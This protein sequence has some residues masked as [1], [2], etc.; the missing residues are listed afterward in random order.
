M[1]EFMGDE[2][3]LTAAGAGGRV[4]GEDRGAGVFHTAPAEATDD[5]LG[6]LVPWVGFIEYSAV[7][8]DHRRR[9]AENLR[10]SLTAA[11]WAVDR[12]VEPLAEGL[13]IGADHAVGGRR[14]AHIG[15][16]ERAD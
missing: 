11:G 5:D 9:V 6:V 10:E 8:L 2:L 16:I 1:G 14:D 12:H 15:D 3:V 4:F 7:V 13:A